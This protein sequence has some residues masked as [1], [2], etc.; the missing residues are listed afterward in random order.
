LSSLLG[1]MLRID[2]DSGV[3]YS[4]PDGNMTGDGVR[5]EIWSYGLRN[6]WRI[7]FDP[8]TA[9]LYIADVGQNLFEEVD[10]EPAGTGG[11]N[12]GWNV[13]ESASCFNPVADDP[14]AE[15][16]SFTN[17][18]ESCNEQGLTPPLFDYNRTWGCSLTGG[19]VYRGAKIPGLVGQYL[20]AD[21]CSGNFGA[22]PVGGESTAAVDITADLNPGGLISFSSFGADHAGELYVLSHSGGAFPT[23]VGDAGVLY[24]IDAE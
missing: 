1:K 18:L 6:P 11:R 2:V 21:Y 12:Y 7:S 22:F 3:P 17:P 15:R 5:P 23:F 14:A 20:Y 13:K 19:G 24:R 9:D 16:P 8:C 4:I 10:F